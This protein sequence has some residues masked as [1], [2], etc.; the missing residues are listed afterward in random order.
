M[1]VQL[2]VKAVKLA[3]SAMR[4]Q[5]N[6]LTALQE[7]SAVLHHLLAQ[8]VPA[9]DIAPEEPLFVPSAQQAPSVARLLQYAQHV[10]ME[11]SVE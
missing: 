5:T 4:P 2:F 3:R 11:H 9:G 8:I 10:P 1:L 7:R 6:A